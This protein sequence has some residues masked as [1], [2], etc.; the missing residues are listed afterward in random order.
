[1]KAKFFSLFII[2]IFLLSCSS[3]YVKQA[4][5][6]EKELQSRLGKDENELTPMI[7]TS[8]GFKLGRIWKAEDPNLEEVSKNTK[9]EIPFSSQEAEQIFSP[10]GKYE[11][12][13]YYKSLGTTTATTQ[14]VT[15]MG[16]SGWKTAE[17]EAERFSYIRV[18]FRDARLVHTKLTQKL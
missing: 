13:L 6:Y 1:M 18:V 4:K 8:W 15:P 7:E 2:S 16:T 14:E 3:A 17:H 12:R 9:W 10:K 5:L 11:V